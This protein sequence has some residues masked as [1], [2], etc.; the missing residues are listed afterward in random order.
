MRCASACSAPVNRIGRPSISIVP[1]SG[2]C[3]PAMILASVDLPAPFSPTRP[4][5]FPAAIEKSTPRSARTAAKLCASPPHRSKREPAAGA[6]E[7]SRHPGSVIRR[8]Q[9]SLARDLRIVGE[10]GGVI[11]RQQ[12]RAESDERLDIPALEFGEHDVHA[13]VANLERV[14]N[15]QRVDLAVLDHLRGHGIE[16]EPYELHLSGL[17]GLFE[18]LIGALEDELIEGE[19]P[20]DVGLG[21]EQVFHRLSRGVQRQELDWLLL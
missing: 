7:A 16:V 19:G 18:G 2:V 3:T 15:Y 12:F 5:T 9:P 6:G 20:L 8:K 4:R 11:F 10:L 17:A 1:V 14:L 13:F 21:D